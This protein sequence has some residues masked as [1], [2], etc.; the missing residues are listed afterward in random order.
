MYTDREKICRSHLFLNTLRHACSL[1]T[2]VSIYTGNICEL[3]IHKRVI[4]FANIQRIQMFEVP[5]MYSIFILWIQSI[6]VLISP[7]LLSWS[8][9]RNL[10]FAINLVYFKKLTTFFLLCSILPNTS[11]G[12]WWLF[13]LNFRKNC[14]HRNNLSFPEMKNSFSYEILNFML[15]FILI[16]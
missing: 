5:F 16:L 6:N 7:H 3:R 11:S 2:P 4:Q 9:N 1:H 14:Q 15:V 8:C 10:K 12:R 13:V